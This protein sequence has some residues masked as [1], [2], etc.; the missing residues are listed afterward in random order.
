MSPFRLVPF[1]ALFL[2]AAILSAPPVV[3]HELWIETSAEGQIGQP[4][5]IEVC[6]GHSG[7]KETGAMLAQQSSKLS[8]VA[9]SPDG[10]AQPLALALGSDSYTAL[11]TPRAPGYRMIGAELQVGIIDREFH[12]IPAHTRIVM[13]GKSFTHVPG[14]EKGLDN[15]LGFD[16]EIVPAGDPTDFHPGDVVAARVLLRGKPIG[17]REVVVSLGTTGPENLPQHSGVSSRQWSIEANAERPAGQVSFPL[18][19]AGQHL[20]SIRY[21]DETP[22]TYRGDLDEASEFSHLRKGDT[23]ERTMY[24]S[25]FAFEVKGP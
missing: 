17:G 18:I 23:F 9:T 14:S 5:K 25:T 12:G 15:T 21:F 11:L 7:A 13:Y 8:A 22:G 20:F 4:Q 19:A 24:V 3:A 16:L 1:G 2:V 10:Q 6:W